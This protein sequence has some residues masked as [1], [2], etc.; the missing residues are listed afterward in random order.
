MY[1][2]YL[3]KLENK[4]SRM[5]IIFAINVPYPHGMAGSMRIR[6]FAEY[7][8]KQSNDVQII[9]TNQDNGIN[10]KEGSFNQVLFGGVSTIAFSY[11]LYLTIYPFLVCLKL[12]LEKKKKDNNCLIIYG[13]PDIYTIPFIIFGKLLGYKVILDIVE[14]RFLTEEKLSIKANINLIFGKIISPL[15]IKAVDGIIVISKHLEKKYKTQSNLLLKLIPVSAVNL[16][17]TTDLYNSNNSFLKIVYSGSFGAK[18]GVDNLIDA[19]IQISQKNKKVKLILI[20]SPKIE[21]QNKINEIENKYI[22]VTGYLP[23]DEYIR[24]L[25]GADILCMTRIDSQYANAGFPFKLGEYLATGKPVVATDVSDI[26]LY[27]ED[28]KDVILAKPSNIQSLVDAL[29]YLIVCPEKREAIGV[30][31]LKKCKKFF[32]PEIN[33]KMLLDFVKNIHS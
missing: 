16:R 26:R 21:I 7:L 24:K 15:M 20:G 1:D 3:Y 13:E 19:F 18:D 6:L 28:K 22:E 12:K 2:I 9:I 27:L 32:N 33:S 5:N 23:D 10:S 30:S 11:Y 4:Y 14:D 29:N 8:A 31:G 17:E 25:H